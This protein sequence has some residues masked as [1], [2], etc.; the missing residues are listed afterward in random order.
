VKRVKKRTGVG[1]S[2]NLKKSRKQFFRVKP[3][4]KESTRE[5]GSL[6]ML[7]PYARLEKAYGEQ[8]RCDDC[9]VVMR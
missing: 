3:T 1:G 8:K 7:K 5:N 4:P 9:F 2:N 6:T